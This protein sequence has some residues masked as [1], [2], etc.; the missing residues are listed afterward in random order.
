MGRERET[1][2]DRATSLEYNHVKVK[3]NEEQFKA[4]MKDKAGEVDANTYFHRESLQQGD[5]TT[6]LD[7]KTHASQ[8][9]HNSGAGCVF[10]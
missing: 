9:F 2:A 4:E 7:T 1:S 5:Q 10:L 3:T 6:D 8:G